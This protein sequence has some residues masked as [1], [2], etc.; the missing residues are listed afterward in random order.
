MHRSPKYVQVYNQILKMIKQGQLIPGEKLP[1]EEVLRTEFDVSRVTLRTALS[2][3]KEDGVLVSVHGKGHFI[4]RENNFSERGIESLDSPIFKSLT[5]PVT[6]REVYYHENLPSAFTDQLFHRSDEPYYTLNIWYQNDDGNLANNL[7]IIM[8]ETV[9]T[10]GIDLED[11]AS[12]TQFLEK[13]LYQHAAS[14]QLTVTVSERDRST[15]RR[16][17][18]GR[19]PLVLMTEDVFGLNGQ[20]LAQNKYYVPSDVF[21]TTLNRYPIKFQNRER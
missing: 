6:D 18:V 1:S 13:D 11:S 7:A 8:P 14:S 4:K 2:L 9:K 5:T 17:F 16:A 20:R 15:F 19:G 3:L 10:F 21:R 12:I